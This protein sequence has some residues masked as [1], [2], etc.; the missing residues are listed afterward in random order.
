[1]WLYSFFLKLL[2]CAVLTLLT[3]CL[4]KA[5]YKVDADSHKVLAGSQSQLNTRSKKT[6][7]TTKLLSTILIF[8]LIAEF[9]QVRYYLCPDR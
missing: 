5:L 2:P 9:P 3:T 7:K 8:F 6:D 1:M 4:I